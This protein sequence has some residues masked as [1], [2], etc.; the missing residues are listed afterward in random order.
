[1]DLY[2]LLFLLMINKKKTNQIKSKIVIAEKK[3]W[4]SQRFR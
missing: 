4:K 3:S 1:M 2:N